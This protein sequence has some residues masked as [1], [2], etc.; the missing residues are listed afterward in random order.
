MIRSKKVALPVILISLLC[1]GAILNVLG[2]PKW[3][4]LS[5]LWAPQTQLIHEVIW[6]MRLPRMVA[7]VLVGM[8][9]AISGALLQTISRNPLADPS[10]LGINAGANLALI[11]GGV[12]GL[13]LTIANTVWLALVGAGC[14]FAA[15]IILSMSKK[16]LDPLRL[17]LGG[18]IFSGFVSC[19]SFAL[20]LVTNTTQQFKNLLVGGFSGVTYPQVGLLIIVTLI[21][22]G[23]AIA[24]RTGF[25]LLAMDEKTVVGLGISV[26]TLWMMAAFLVILASGASVAVGGNIGFVGLGMPQL[27][28]VLHPGS[29]KQNLGLTAI[30]G[31]VFMVFADLLA[32]TAAA[33]VELPLSG[34]SA[35]FGGVLLFMI[36]AFRRQVI[37]P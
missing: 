30:A 8:L 11:I 15:V 3:Y 17:I 14:A 16:G 19:V 2:G 10:I 20:S 37:R 1:V 28:N 22:L 13:T 34:L 29:F 5:D 26:R 25:T 35:L 7:S 24:F 4:H 6:T 9:L 21:V 33:T 32:K 18:T 23:L 31:G 12:A 36:V 27:V